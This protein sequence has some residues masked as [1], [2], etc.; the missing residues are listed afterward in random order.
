VTRRFGYS[1]CSHRGDCPP[2][3]YDFPARGF[4]TRFEPRHLDGPHFPH[5]NSRPTSSDGEV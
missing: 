5:R 3:R 1:P 4:Y 2:G